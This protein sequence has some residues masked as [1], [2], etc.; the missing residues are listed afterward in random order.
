MSLDNRDILKSFLKAS[1][2]RIEE[3]MRKFLHP[4][5][6]VIE[7][8]SLP[9]GGIH[10]GPDAFMELIPT[11]FGTWRDCNVKVNKWISE[12]DC[13]ILLGVMTGSGRTTGTPFEV[14]I[15]EVWTFLDGKII[16]VVPYYFDTKMLADVAGI[17]A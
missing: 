4:E 8:D 2:R 1:E 14:P 11:V 17:D 15:A 16:E 9:Y 10:E 6:R 7:A 12:G 5:I 13:V 3:E